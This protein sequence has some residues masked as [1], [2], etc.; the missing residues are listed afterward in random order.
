MSN[1]EKLWGGRFTGEADAVF[2]DFNRSFGF[3]RRLFAADIAGSI[4]HA[5][6]LCGAG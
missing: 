5:N 2:A 3:D 4:A 6:G 1:S